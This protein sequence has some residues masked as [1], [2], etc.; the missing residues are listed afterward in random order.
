MAVTI[1]GLRA[2]L[3]VATVMLVAVIA[4]YVEYAR[5]R[6]TD[7]LKGLP[8]KYGVDITTDGVSFSHALGAN[9]QFTL[10]AGRQVQ[11]QDG[12]ISLQDVGIVLYGVK[13][14]RSDRIHGNRFEYD[15][16]AGVLEG[17]GEV[18]I[19]LAAPASAAEKG[20]LKAKAPAA[21]KTEEDARI[22]HVKASG[23][24]FLVNAGSAST[25]EP[26]EFI[27]GGMTG[28][29]IGASYDSKTGVVVLRSAVHL[30]GLRNE[31][32]V[33]IT[34]G[35][36]ELDR[37]G[38][39]A[40]LEGAKAILAGDDGA[41]TVAADHAL[42]HM[43]AD[44]SP[45][46]IDGQGHVELTGDGH[47]TSHGV[48]DGDRMQLDLN[49]AG[50][51]QSGLMSGNVRFHDDAPTRQEDGRGQ[52]MQAAF[53]AQGRPV[54]SVLTG[55]AELHV[56]EGASERRLN[57]AKVDL[58]LG[59][60]GKE[61]VFVK[62]AVA[63]GDDG[64]RLRMLGKSGK[65]RQMTTATGMRADTL[66]ARFATAAAKPVKNGL[67]PPLVGVDGTGKTHLE[68]VVTD[69]K[70]ALQSRQTSTG[71]VLK[72][73]FVT[74]DD[75]KTDLKRAEQRGSVN[76]VREAAVAAKNA[77]PAGNSTVAPKPAAGQGTGKPATQ[78]EHAK[79]DVAVYDADADVTTLTGDVQVQDADAAVFA[80][81]VVS[82]RLTGDSVAEGA[83]RVTYLQAGSTGEPVHVLAARAVSHKARR[84]D[85]VLRG[86]GCP[87]RGRVCGRVGSQVEAPRLDFDQTKRMLVAKDVAGGS[88]AVVKT[89][90]VD[91][92]KADVPKADAPNADASKPAESKSE[93]KKNNAPMRVYSEQM[94]YTDAIRL[95]EFK[96]KVRA[97]DGDGTL[98]AQ[99][100]LVYL[101]KPDDSSK[102][103]PADAKAEPIDLGGRVDH[104]VATG[105]V[106]LQQPGRLATGEKLTYAASDQVFVLTGSKSAPPKMVD[107]LQGMTTGAALRFRT[108]DDSVVVLSGEYAGHVRSETRMKQ[109]NSGSQGTVKQEKKPSS[110]AGKKP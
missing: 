89:V 74:G 105:A 83:V 50:Q 35:W 93:P 16:K 82:Q 70:G 100:A 6:A 106:E 10:H 27:A 49:A 25:S 67:G 69:A 108:G 15:P 91:S 20:T 22:I 29:S 42:V 23:V 43:R 60:G 4:G 101:A 59:G 18:F 107:D 13:S 12:K 104:M 76:I 34:A 8:G 51:P 88:G 9:T 11:H 38:N 99:D 52:E 47:G 85:G 90:I 19:D 54:H 92:P 78:V 62:G 40:K 53:D 17:V 58:D 1:K 68:Q 31:R 64:A 94:I 55:D 84:V 79:A 61:P 71:D 45:Q 46:R 21:P 110:G 5:H 2:G 81:K 80:D 103:A 97:E 57:A 65:D 75:G 26:V 33:V 63:T 7:W 32:P 77:A 95:V 39:L 3:V 36:A 72:L 28:K 86:S 41:R 98:H 30:S 14:D 24:T 56:R 87:E 48:A 66:V 102:T 37:Q 73:D 96:G 44:G 109:G